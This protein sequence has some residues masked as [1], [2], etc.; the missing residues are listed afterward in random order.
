MK[1]NYNWGI[2][3]CGKIAR[4]FCNDL[5][6]LPQANLYAAASRSLDKAN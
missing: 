2:L 4:T 6:L 3:G 5:Q 1:K